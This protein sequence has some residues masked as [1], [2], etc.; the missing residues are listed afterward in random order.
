[1]LK[2]SVEAKVR[3]LSNTSLDKASLVGAARIY[4]SKDTLVSLT[5]TL[6]NGKLCIVEK[7]DDAPAVRRGASLWILPEKNLNQNV[8]MM[9]RAFQEATGFKIGDQVRISIA[10]P[11]A[12]PALV[13]VLAEDV[14]DE[15]DKDEK[16]S[17][18]SPSWEHALSLSLG[19]FLV[20]PDLQ[21]SNLTSCRSSRTHLSWHGI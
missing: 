10:E 19:M 8:V 21:T 17:R 4:V 6:N 1:M 9:T 20:A 5:G 3:P 16:P 7:L 18:H 11:S 15:K 2:K 12:T 14:S 13:E